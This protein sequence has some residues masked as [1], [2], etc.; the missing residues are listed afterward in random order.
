[1]SSLPEH[2]PRRKSDAGK[3]PE[4]EVERLRRLCAQMGGLLRGIR[5]E[6]LAMQDRQSP[7]GFLQVHGVQCFS[8]SRRCGRP[9]GDFFDFRATNPDEL[10]AG[11]GN[12]PVDGV[13]GPILVCQLHAILRSVGAR[14]A[15]L[16]AL[17]G[18]LNHMLWDGAPESVSASFFCARINPG[19]GRLHYVNAGHAPALLL[20]A[21]GRAERLDPNSAMLGLSRRSTYIQRTI[22]FQPGDTLMAFTE[23]AEEGVIDL[24]RD[25]T[26]A[27]STKCDSIRDLPSRIIS[28]AEAAP[29]HGISDRTVVVVHYSGAESRS[30]APSP[31]SLRLKTVAVAAAA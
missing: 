17:M 20:R 8:Q 28:A 15:D 12:V 26:A 18:E 21:G 11:V 13:A 1:M 25:G 3:H 4:A 27:V 7:A 19:L 5:E 30:V 22:G 6:A 29:A 23:G 31:A 24:L 9:G 10:M 2:D 16:P 14:D